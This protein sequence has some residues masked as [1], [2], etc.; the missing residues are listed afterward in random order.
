M[1]YHT[2]YQYDTSDTDLYVTDGYTDSEGNAGTDTDVAG[3]EL[4]TSDIELTVQQGAEVHFKFDADGST[5]D[6]LLT[7][8]KRNDVTW[9]GNEAAWRPVLT[10]AND[11]TETEYHYTISPD[12]GAGHYRWGMVRSGSTNTFDIHVTL[13]KWRPTTGIA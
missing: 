11:G 12:A 3:T 9:T 5:D 6:L 2:S 8:Y 13:R 1:G 10:A 7:L 4:F